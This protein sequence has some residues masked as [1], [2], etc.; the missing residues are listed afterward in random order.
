M[1]ALVLGMF[2]VFGLA[3]LLANISRSNAEMARANALAENG[4]FAMQVLEANISHAGFWGGF[5]PQFDDLSYSSA[6]T[7]RPTAL[8]DPCLSYSTANWNVAHLQRL[9]GIPIQVYEV[10]H[11]GTL[12]TIGTCAS[13]TMIAD[14]QPDTHVVV[15]RHLAPCA[16]SASA[17][18]EDCTLQQNAVY[19]QFGRCSTTVTPSAITIGTTTTYSVPTGHGLTVGMVIYASNATGSTAHKAA[20]NGVNA[21]V[22]AVDNTASPNTVT[23]DIDT[24][25]K[26]SLGVDASTTLTPYYAFGQASDATLS[27]FTLKN[28]NCT[29]TADR[30]KLVTHL[31]YVRKYSSSSGDGLPTLVRR[32]F[33]VVG[34]TPTLDAV[35]P[36]VEGVEGFRVEF[37]LDNVSKSGAALTT[38]GFDSAVTWASSTT[39]VTPTNRGDGN[40]DSFGQCTGSDHTFS[41]TTV[42]AYTCTAFDLMNAVVARIYVLSRAPTTTPDHTDS[43]TYAL[44]KVS[45]DISSAAPTIS[46]TFVLGPYG[47]HYK[48]HVYSTTVRLTNVS[49][50]REVP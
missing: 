9:I 25:G 16:A 45:N 5:V 30:F 22:T 23:V 17:T 44:G 38:T 28:R 50:R 39:R 46:S 19:F 18:D 6:P 12:P 41:G 4:R 32:K 26:A 15:V 33:R 7:D 42:P 27:N 37:G 20:V 10:A 47:D 35:E 24:T 2:I 21:R 8:P 29:T 43:R 13:S 11:D 36:L 34:S 1:V 31:Y 3:T 49:M 14:A 48:R 40:P